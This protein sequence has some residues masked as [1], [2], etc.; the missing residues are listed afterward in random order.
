MRKVI[1][2]IFALLT[3]TAATAQRQALVGVQQKSQR[4]AA[5]SQAAQ[6]QAVAPR[7]VEGLSSLQRPVGHWPTDSITLKDVAMG[8]A[9]TY[10]IGAFLTNS[11]LRSYAGC[12][13]VGVRFAVGESIGRT[14][15]FVYKVDEEGNVIGEPVTQNQRT[16]EGWN[17]VFFNAGKE[18][19]LDGTENLIVGYDYV[20]SDA[21]VAA[22]H[23]AI[24]TVGMEADEAD[25]GQLTGY[26]F[27]IYGNFGQGDGWWSVTNCGM[28]CAQLILDVS[29][30]P[31]KAVDMSYLDTGFRYKQPGEDIDLLATVLN[32]GREDVGSYELYAQIDDMAP[33]SIASTSVLSEGATEDH[34]YTLHLPADIA[35]GRHTVRVGVKTVEGEAVE[36]TDRNVIEQQFYVYAH[37]LQRKMV[38]V[39]N[40]TDQDDY[41]SA[42]M[43]TVLTSVQSQFPQACVVNVYKPGNPLA[44]SESAYLNDLYAYTLPCFTSN[45]AYFP[46]EAY[47][48]YDVNYY[49]QMV[50]PSFV[51]SIVHDVVAQ[52]FDFASFATIEMN[53]AYDPAT[54]ELTVDVSGTLSE[55]ALPIYG[56][57]AV[58]LMLTEDKVTSYQYYVNSRN[59]VT[60]SNNYQHNHVLRAYL[61]APTGDKVASTGGTYQGRFTIT[62]DEA[63]KPENLN[64]VGLVTRYAESVTASNLKEMDVTNADAVALKS[65]VSGISEISEGSEFSEPSEPSY[66]LSG[67]RVGAGYRGIVVRHGK[68]Y[69]AK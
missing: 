38:Y 49:L 35:V 47:I 29:S 10:P 16:Y 63:W 41:T 26:E 69:L 39:E 60:R 31:A 66:N 4:V 61:T 34:L 21:M 5:L 42:Q 6:P 54:R 64:L 33:E 17:N 25:E 14:R 52:D 50:G 46:G 57:V 65:V 19:V 20:E 24:C 56:D 62:L 59:L 51:V 36:T 30:L 37:P 18:F 1:F 22:D 8:S 2:A 15:A 3:A 28:L 7:R 48:A 12:K 27:V 13:V 32:A 55:D 53:P 44:I 67:Q 40:F 68:K 11:M 58:T 43:N 23:G 45:R 9:D